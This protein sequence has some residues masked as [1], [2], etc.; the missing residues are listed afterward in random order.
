MWPFS[1]GLPGSM[2]R[3]VTLENGD[4]TVVEPMAFTREGVGRDTRLFQA[5]KRGGVFVARLDPAALREWRRTEVWGGV[6]QRPGFCRRITASA[7]S[8]RRA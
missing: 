3:V 2:K 8:D 1:E 5:P 6:H 4:S 7:P